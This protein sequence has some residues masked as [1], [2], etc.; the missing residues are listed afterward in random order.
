MSQFGI[1]QCLMETINHLG[2]VSLLDPFRC[3]LF[4]GCH[5]GFP[6]LSSGYFFAAVVG[7][8]VMSSGAA[9]IEPSSVF[10]RMSSSP[11]F[12]VAL[13]VRNNVICFPSFFTWIESACPLNSALVM[14][15]K[16]LSVYVMPRPSN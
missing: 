5:I 16:P 2:K 8:G 12:A 14:A 6:S 9:G 1:L 10:N 15:V 4:L 11:G 3:L 13:S 7:A